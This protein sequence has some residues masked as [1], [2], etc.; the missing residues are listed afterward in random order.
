MRWTVNGSC[1]LWHLFRIDLTHTIFPSRVV[2]GGG[3]FLMTSTCC[4]VS[5]F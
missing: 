3:R 1:I 5:F 2:T 4:L